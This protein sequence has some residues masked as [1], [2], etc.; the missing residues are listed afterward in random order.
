[1]FDPRTGEQNIPCTPSISTN[2]DGRRPAV[3]NA[4]GYLM[5]NAQ[6]LIQVIGVD[7]LRIDAA[8][9]VQGFVLDF[10]DRA[11]YR[12]NPRRLLDG[13]DATCSPTARSS[14]RTPRFSCRTSRRRSIP[15]TPAASAAIAT[16]WTSSCTSRSRTTWSR[17]ASP[18]AWQRIK[19][20]AL[21]MSD[22]GLHNGSAGVTFTHNHDVFKPFAL[23]HVAQAY[24]LMM[25]GNTVV[26]F[27][28]REFGDNRD[29]PKPGRGDALSVG[30]GSLLTRLLEARATAR[31]RQ[32]R[33][34]VGWDRWSVRLRAAAARRSCSCPIAETP[35]ST[36]G[37][38][39]NVGFRPGQLLVELSGNAA[40]PSVNPDRGGGTGTSRR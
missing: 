3:E 16:R 6:W 21:D 39:R 22:D 14:T 15:A 32:L 2:P 24:T 38:S 19:D 36:P 27:N 8:K 10:L 7:G 33:R 18:G 25:P 35:D 29:F 40:D 23:E 9:H 34:T 28:G 12:Q 5:R 30:R 31:P 4:T 13:S 37:R 20:A 26:Y 11:V 1:M 17:P